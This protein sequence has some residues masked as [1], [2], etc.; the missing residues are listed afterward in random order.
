M[1]SINPA[2]GERIRDYP[3][4]P[5][6]YLEERLLLAGAAFR[7]WSRRTLAERCAVLG[8]AARLLRDGADRHATLMS[9]EM[10]KPITEGRAEVEKCAWVCRFYAEQAAAYPAAPQDVETDARKSCV[11]FDPLGAVLGDHA[12]ELP[13]LAGLPLRGAALWRG[14]VALL[15]HASNVPGCALA[16]EEVWRDAGSLRLLFRRC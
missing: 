16:I 6:E 13:L 9:T 15:K 2:T 11:R 5:T 12:V 10:G 4:H 14:N 8:K 3:D 7:S 1:R